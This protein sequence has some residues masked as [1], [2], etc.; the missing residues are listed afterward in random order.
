M[1]DEET[2]LE[3]AN[4]GTKLVNDCTGTTVQS[5]GYIS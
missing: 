2:R 4:I 5:V 1:K 3:Q